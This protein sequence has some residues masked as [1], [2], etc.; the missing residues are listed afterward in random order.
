[1]TMLTRWGRD[2]DAERVLPEHPRPQLV[3]GTWR[4]LNGWWEHAVTPADVSEPPADGAWDGRILVPFSPEAPLSGVGRQVQPDELLWYRR[5][6]DVPT[7]FVPPGG[8]LLLHFGAV[9][10][11]ATVYVDGQEVGDHH[12]GYLPFTVDLTD[13]VSPG[14]RELVVRVRDLSNNRGPSSG[15]QRLVRGGIWYTAQSGIWQTVWLEA[16]P[17]RYVAELHL[18]PRLDDGTVEVTVVAAGAPSR[19]L[20]TVRVTDGGRLV[21]GAAAPAGVPTTVR[22]SAVRPWT[23]DDPHLY[24]VEVTLGADRVRSYVGMRS[25]AVGTDESGTPRLLLNGEPFLHAGVL[26]Q[27]YWPDGLL[28]PPSDEA[29]VHDIST[30]KRLGFTM[31]RKHIKVEPL[32]WYHHCDR[33]GM[34][35]WQ[36]MV[37]GGG[38]YRTA[39]VTWPGRLPSAGRRLRDDRYAVFGRTDSHGRDEFRREA[40]ATVELLRNTPSVVCWVPFNEGWGQFDAAAVAAEVAALDPTRVV[41][42]ASGWHDQGAG[43][44][45]SLHVYQRRFRAPRRAPEE[46]RVLA[47]TE[48]G[49]YD[50]TVPDHTWGPEHMGYRHFDTVT[51]LAAAFERLHDDELV[52]TVGAGLSAT[53]YTQLCDVEDEVNGLLTYDREVLKID[54]A[55]VRAALDRL[56]A[57]FTASTSAGTGR[58]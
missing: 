51:A 55:V 27:G 16:V 10:Q 44:V 52:P 34:L 47:L 49:G 4:S 45:W 28:T 46:R 57:A 8:R 7:G 17:A 12:G 5:T 30:M 1:M 9:D 23:P 19:D 20:A 39:A 58:P 13:A 50:L 25:V 24:G 37:N 56:R 40:R 48:Y 43:D 42:H 2:L 11:T 21:G 36:D 38:R 41:D 22:L 31:L 35:V 6:L 53:V 29:M 54:E 3:R 15:K 33:L 32:R 18:V 14:P 26:D